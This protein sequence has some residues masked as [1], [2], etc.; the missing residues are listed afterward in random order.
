MTEFDIAKAMNELAAKF[1]AASDGQ[2]SSLVAAVH[3]ARAAGIYKA[4]LRAGLTTHDKIVDHYQ[5]SMDFLM[6]ESDPNLPPVE[7]AYIDEAGKV[8]KTT[9]KKH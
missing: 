3:L 5:D 6:A 1:K 8:T 4:L 2:H 9:G 7:V